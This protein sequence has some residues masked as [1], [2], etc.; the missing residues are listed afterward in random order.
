MEFCFFFKVLLTEEAGFLEA[1]AGET[2]TQF[3][4][5]QIA[6]S[7]DISAAAKSFELKLEFGPYRFSF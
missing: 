1:D 3:T 2:T 6:E 5:K 4:Q 7:V